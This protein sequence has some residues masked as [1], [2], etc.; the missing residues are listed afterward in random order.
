MLNDNQCINISQDRAF[1]GTKM[2]VLILAKN[3]KAAELTC[4]VLEKSGLQYAPLWV[5]TRQVFLE[6]L[7]PFISIVPA[8]Y[9]P[10]YF[11]ALDAVRDLQERNLDITVILPTDS[12]SEDCC[13][14]Y[15]KR[16]YR[17]FAEGSPG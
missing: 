8:D 16:R 1:T 10:P 2:M 6:S 3:L 7:D 17:L 4:R 11:S 14:L 15:Q 12:F 9:N 5:D 13:D